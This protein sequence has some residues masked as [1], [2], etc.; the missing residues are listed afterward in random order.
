MFNIAQ[1]PKNDGY[2]C[3]LALMLHKFFDKEASGGTVRNEN[4]FTKELAELHKPIIR[5]F[6][7][8]PDFQGVLN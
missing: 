1:N 7:R 5:A 3:G 6:K 8:N 4:V 2:Q